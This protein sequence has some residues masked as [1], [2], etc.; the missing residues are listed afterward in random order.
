MA[1]TVVA[2]ALSIFFTC[3]F[4]V[5]GLTL[6]AFYRKRLM[7]Y[8]VRPWGKSVLWACG[9]KLVVEGLE[10]LPSEPS[11]LMYNH[12]S[13]FDIVAFS[14]ALPIEWRAVMKKEVRN[15]PF[16]GWVSK[17]AGHYFV[18]RDGS[19]EDSREVKRMVAEL[20]KGP[21]LI[22]APEGTRSEDG[23]LLP[24]KK[25]GF[26]VAML[27][28][29]PVVPIVIWGGKNIRKKGTYELHP[30]KTITVH[31]LEPVDVRKLPRGKE[32]REELEKIVRERMN[33]VIEK[34]LAEEARE[35]AH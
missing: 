34:H 24:F 7:K 27:A 13:S 10:N 22:I 20:K 29:V 1:R 26:V 31:I 25:G 28:Q 18:S 15:I 17:L 16:V 3:F 11:I 8:A 32:G 30:N 9:V 6:A 23:R 4:G 12:Q 5:V 35:E 2:W 19:K 33:K 21:S 14:A